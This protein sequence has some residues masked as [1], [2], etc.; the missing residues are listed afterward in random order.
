MRYNILYQ[1][2]TRNNLTAFL[3]FYYHYIMQN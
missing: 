2:K 1:P 3:G